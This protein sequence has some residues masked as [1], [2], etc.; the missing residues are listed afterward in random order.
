MIDIIKKYRKHNYVKNSGIIAASLVLAFGINFFVLDSSLGQKLQISVI[1]GLE[2]GN[3]G[4]LYLQKSDTNVNLISSKD[5]NQVKSLSLS[6][7]YNPTNL[8][9]GTINSMIGGNIINES[10]ED[11]LTTLII[12]FSSPLD[13]KKGVNIV[14]LTVSKT[15]EKLENINIISA[16][17]T[18]SANQV[19]LLSS[20][21]VEY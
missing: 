21:G 5:M 2:N 18:D 1:N 20:S 4:D 7:V 6:I 12:N 13:I 10:N 9:I 16:N 8:K 19:Y 3:V 15:E 14:N 17:F 11:G